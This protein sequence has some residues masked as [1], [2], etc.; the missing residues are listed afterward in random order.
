MAIVII[1]VFILDI[2]LY[3]AYYRMEEMKASYAAMIPLVTEGVSM[4]ILVVLLSA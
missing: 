4:G 3:V 2:V 1:A